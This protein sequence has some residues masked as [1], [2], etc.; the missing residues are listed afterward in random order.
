M[1]SFEPF[2]KML[3]EQGIS[4]YSLEYDYE[5]NPAEISQL[6]NNHNFTLKFIKRLCIL[7]HCQPGD[8]I[9]FVELDEKV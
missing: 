1:I 7:F 6:K 4:L 8:I 3:K 5:F 9:N 2:W